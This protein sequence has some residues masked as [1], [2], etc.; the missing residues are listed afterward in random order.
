MLHGIVGS[1]YFCLSTSL[2]SIFLWVNVLFRYTRTNNS[3]LTTSVEHFQS[4]EM[5][6][7]PGF[8][9]KSWH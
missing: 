2:M 5:T 9:P 7:P 8:K 6:S 3:R 4:I 1:Q